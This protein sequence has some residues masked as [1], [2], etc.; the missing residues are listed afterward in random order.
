MT[1]KDV[2]EQLVRWASEVPGRTLVTE[3]AQI[4]ETVARLGLR[5]TQRATADRT[6]YVMPFAAKDGR[7]TLTLGDAF[8]DLFYYGE[9]T[10]SYRAFLEMVKADRALTVDFF[11]PGH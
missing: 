8:C 4:A 7:L 5:R 2:R 3:K 9:D 1:R 6:A 11:K 10:E